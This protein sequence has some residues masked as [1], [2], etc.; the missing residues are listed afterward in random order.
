MV[1]QRRADTR[2]EPC[3][4]FLLGV[5]TR[6]FGFLPQGSTAEVD[7]TWAEIIQSGGFAETTRI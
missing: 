6:G 2:D 1:S 5:F 4:A 7:N 3:P